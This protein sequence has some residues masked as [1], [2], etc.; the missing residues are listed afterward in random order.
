MQNQ[1]KILLEC[2]IKQIVQ[3][4]FKNVKK[5]RKVLKMTIFG[6]TWL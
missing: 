6:Q 4:F 2:Q 3:F 5:E 1:A